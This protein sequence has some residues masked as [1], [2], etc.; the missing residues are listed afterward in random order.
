MK[1]DFFFK[2]IGKVH[3]CYAYR[4]SDNIVNLIQTVPAKSQEKIKIILK[5]FS[6]KKFRKTVDFLLIISYNHSW[7]TNGINASYK[8]RFVN[9]RG[10]K[11]DFKWPSMQR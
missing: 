5:S 7:T 9:L 4:V 3:P 10:F 6:F 2:C 11:S 1:I 8:P